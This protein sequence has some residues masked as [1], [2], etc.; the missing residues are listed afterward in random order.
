MSAR[1]LPWKQGIFNKAYVWLGMD[2]QQLVTEGRLLED[3]L[4]SSEQE[5]SLLKM[6]KVWLLIENYL[7][8]YNRASAQ[9]VNIN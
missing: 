3:T 4:H 6:P 8:S 1:L 9:L 7:T 5:I 2:V